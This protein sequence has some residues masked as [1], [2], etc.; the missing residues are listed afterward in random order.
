MRLRCHLRVRQYFPN[1]PHSFSDRRRSQGD[2]RQG[3]AAVYA[4]VCRCS[5]LC[6]LWWQEPVG[7]SPECVLDCRPRRIEALVVNEFGNEIRACFQR[8]AGASLGELGE[9][10]AALRV[11]CLDEFDCLTLDVGEFFGPALL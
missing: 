4:I 3:P 8:L 9:E 5:G 7:V 11:A 6:W 1:Q 2:A 10:F